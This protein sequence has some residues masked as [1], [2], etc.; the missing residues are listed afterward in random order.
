VIEVDGRF[1]IPKPLLK[2]F[3]GYDFA[4]LLKQGRKQFERLA[5]KPDAHTG[6]AQFSGLQ[7]GFKDAEL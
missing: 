1:R 3:A 2:G 6:T 5:L 4:G 7:I